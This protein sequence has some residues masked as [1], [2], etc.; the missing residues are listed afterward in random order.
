[1]TSPLRAPVYSSP[2]GV[3]SLPPSAQIPPG[4]ARRRTVLRGCLPHV[5]E[6]RRWMETVASK[7]PNTHRL[8][9]CGEACPPLTRKMGILVPA[10]GTWA[11]QGPLA[12]VSPACHQPLGAV[13]RF[14]ERTSPAFQWLRLCT[15]NAGDACSIPGQGTKIPHA[16]RHGRKNKTKRRQQQQ[17]KDVGRNGVFGP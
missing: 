12:S 8:A 2:T 13:S 11:P 7:A 9:L 17:Q 15:P 10:R 5:V 1:M 16:L 4:C 6:S 14:R 3:G